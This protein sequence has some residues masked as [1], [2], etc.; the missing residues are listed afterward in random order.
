MKKFL[1]RLF[2]T[3]PMMLKY[4]FKVIS[5]SGG[6]SLGTV[7]VS[8]TDPQSARYAALMSI[9]PGRVILGPAERI[10]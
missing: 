8:A 2:G 10:P 4:S 7:E 6:G 5:P 3:K 9:D 1:Q